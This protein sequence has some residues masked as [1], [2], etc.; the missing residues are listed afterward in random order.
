MSISEG[1]KSIS[2]SDLPVCS[3]SLDKSETVHGKKYRNTGTGIKSNE[4]AE[5]PKSSC[6]LNLD[7]ER[8]EFIVDRESNLVLSNG[9]ENVSVELLGVE[10]V[11]PKITAKAVNATENGLDGI[12]EDNSHLDTANGEDLVMRSD[13]VNGTLNIADVRQKGDEMGDSRDISELAPNDN[14]NDGGSEHAGLSK[15]AL[16]SAVSGCFQELSRRHSKGSGSGSSHSHSHPLP[17][18]LKVMTG[19]SVALIPSLQPRPLHLPL[20]LPLPQP[21]SHS[22]PQSHCAPLLL[23]SSSSLCHAPVSMSLP[24]CAPPTAWSLALHPSSSSLLSPSH[25]AIKKTTHYC[26]DD[27]VVHSYEG[28]AYC[29]K[30]KKRKPYP[31]KIPSPMGTGKENECPQ[32]LGGKSPKC[33][34][35]S[36]SSSTDSRRNILGAIR[37][38]EL[39]S[40]DSRTDISSDINIEKAHS[41]L[42]VSQECSSRSSELA[43]EELEQ[44]YLKWKFVLHP[45]N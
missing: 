4:Y 11:E 37:V 26:D 30:D 2:S 29:E 17:K 35:K 42:A 39:G 33:L 7:W 40:T 12:R 28:D 9:E 3:A 18:H 34:K 1:N 14:Y 38:A 6:T 44:W 5:S 27:E 31:Y 20:S 45:T 36:K 24:L 10:D 22:A 8:M 19:F 13:C 32:S 16:Y 41:A 15:A 43:F 21:Q 25:D 23:P